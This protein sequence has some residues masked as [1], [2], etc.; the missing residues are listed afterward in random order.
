MATTV[1]V[2][3]RVPMPKT[4]GL[5]GLLLG[6]SEG[7]TSLGAYPEDSLRDSKI[8]KGSHEWHAA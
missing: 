1:R 6:L 3:L 8:T 2:Q 4:R 7:L 5:G